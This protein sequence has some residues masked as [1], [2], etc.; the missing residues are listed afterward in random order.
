MFLL[1]QRL[2]LW[3]L[4]SQSFLPLLKINRRK[5]LMM[6]FQALNSLIPSEDLLFAI[7]AVSVGMFGLRAPSWKLKRPNPRKKRPDK[8]IMALDL[9]LSI[10][11]FGI[12]NPIKY[13]GDKHLGISIKPLDLMLL[14]ISGLSSGLYQPITM[15][16]TR[17]NP[18]IWEGLKSNTPVSLLSECRTWW[19]GWCSL[20]SNHPLEGRLG[21]RRAITPRRGTDAPSRFRCSCLGFGSKS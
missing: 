21:L 8:L 4:Q 7:I 6:M 2:Y 1:P 15:A 10:K 11:L 14:S 19:N 12:K 18:S 13:H 17:A 5:R 20:V 3:S 9:R 16:L